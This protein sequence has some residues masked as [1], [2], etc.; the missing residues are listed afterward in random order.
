MLCYAICPHI[1][2]KKRKWSLHEYNLRFNVWSSEEKLWYFHLALLK[3]HLLTQHCLSAVIHHT[4]FELL[5]EPASV[6]RPLSMIHSLSPSVRRS[7]L[8]L[9]SSP[10][11]LFTAQP[12]SSSLMDGWSPWQPQ[13]AAFNTSQIHLLLCNPHNYSIN[14]SLKVTCSAKGSPIYNFWKERLCGKVISGGDW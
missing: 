10:P 12:S 3:T 13:M 7:L 4:G 9:S 8:L 11:L 5:M 6:S 1:L 14:Y 2:P